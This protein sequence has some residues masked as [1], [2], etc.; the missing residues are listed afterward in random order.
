MNLIAVGN[1]LV[2]FCDRF[3]SSV[4][5]FL[6]AR[7]RLQCRQ[8]FPALNNTRVLS[9]IIQFGVM[10]S[11]ELAL[12]VSKVVSIIDRAIF[13]RGHAEAVVRRWPA[14]NYFPVTAKLCFPFYI[15]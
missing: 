7:L 13:D 9:D 2:I 10:S 3:I 11:T 12:R 6:R 5:N 1:R 14:V 15:S 4:L 8:T